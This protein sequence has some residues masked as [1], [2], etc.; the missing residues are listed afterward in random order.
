MGELEVTVRKLDLKDKGNNNYIIC[1]AQKP[2]GFWRRLHYYYYSFR[3]TRRKKL[4]YW[5]NN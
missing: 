5:P 3:K 1:I 2:R 4:L